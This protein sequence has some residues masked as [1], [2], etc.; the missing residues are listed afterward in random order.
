LAW[1]HIARGLHARLINPQS[2]PAE[3]LQLARKIEG[4]LFSAESNISVNNRARIL[5]F[6][7]RT[8]A[9]LAAQRGANGLRHN[10][11]TWLDYD[12]L[13]LLVELP[14][15]DQLPNERV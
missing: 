15:P 8:H 10:A 9:H 3:K 1:V 4:A 14:K 13:Q 11:T 7:L 6:R 5:F 2:P 12:E